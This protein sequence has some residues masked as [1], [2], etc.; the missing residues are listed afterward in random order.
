VATAPGD[1]GM[2]PNLRHGLDGSYWITGPRSVFHSHDQGRTWSEA[3][4][5]D[6]APEYS[7]DLYPGDGNAIY[8]IW[9]GMFRVWRSADGGVNWTELDVPFDS[10]GTEMSLSWNGSST[11]ELI[12]YRFLLSGPET[13]RG[14][15]LAYY[16]I[17]E[18]G[19]GFERIDFDGDRW[20]CSGP[21]PAVVAETPSAQFGGG[22]YGVLAVD[23]SWIP[24]PFP[25]RP[26]NC[27][28][29]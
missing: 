2:M 25:C 18:S 5:P 3:Q 19:A 13:L 28:G 10:E 8:A 27:R 14:Q 4:F 17:S 26:E 6:G 15:I 9:S 12:L 11:G 29:F 16:R 20:Y 24:L 7:F 21:V 1:L 22:P 23:G